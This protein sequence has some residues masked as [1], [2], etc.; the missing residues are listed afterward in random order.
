MGTAMLR[1][2]RAAREAKPEPVEP[3]GN[4]STAEWAAWAAHLGIEVPDGTKRDEI[5]DLVAGFVP[6]E[7]NDEGITSVTTVDALTPPPVG[8]GASVAPPVGEQGSEPLVPVADGKVAP[9]AE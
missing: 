7:P 1:R 4:G 9:P 8:D 6:A 3:K 5:K 2:H